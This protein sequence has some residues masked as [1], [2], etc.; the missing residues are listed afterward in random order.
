[1]RLSKIE[2][3]MNPLENAIK[4][5]EKYCYESPQEL[6]LLKLLYAEDLKLKEEPL[7]DCEGKILFDNEMGLITLNNKIKDER[8]KR[9]TLAH[10]M[11]HFFNEKHLIELKKNNYTCGFEEFY[12]LNKS[13]RWENK[14]NEFAAELLMHKPWFQSFT[15][16]KLPG[17]ELIQETSEYFKV[18]LTATALR[19]VF[20]GQYPTAIIMSKDGKVLWSAINEYFPLK[21]I[22]VG[23]KVRK[24]SA[25]YDYFDC[26]EVQ[27]CKDLIP[28]YTWFSDDFKCPRDLYFYEQ[29]F[30][31]YNYDCVLTMLWEWEG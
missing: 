10:E 20:I 15:K 8:Q 24:E 27:K 13:K 28:A 29:N 2:T 31:M 30:V 19:Y 17:M 14:A 21:W 23:Y 5:I 7:N 9:F 1:M 25:A 18:S 12:G 6:D 22:P 4:L 3:K 11:G 26:K 16:N